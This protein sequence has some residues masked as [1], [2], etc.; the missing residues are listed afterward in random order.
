MPD[1]NDATAAAQLDAAFRHAFTLHMFP[2]DRAVLEGEVLTRTVASFRDV[3]AA[4]YGRRA[5]TTAELAAS[6]WTRPF[7]PTDD[8]HTG[9]LYRIV[10]GTGPRDLDVLEYTY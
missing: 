4:C 8:A 1:P 5:Y 10:A 9:T 2:A 7:H 3:Y 6:G